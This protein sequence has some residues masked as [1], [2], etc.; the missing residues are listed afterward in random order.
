MMQPREACEWAR[1][2]GR[3]HS[4]SPPSAL[5][6]ERKPRSMSYP[7][8]RPRELAAEQV[9][10]GLDTERAEAILHEIAVELRFGGLGD[11]VVPLHVR[12][13]ALK[14]EVA[15]WS[16]RENAP[17]EAE[18]QSTIEELLALHERVKAARERQR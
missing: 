17:E 11:Q 3:A 6:L 5:R 18:R 8:K 9:T 4:P 1:A 15:G 16:S 2:P 13:L 10:L 12:A 14:R 7:P